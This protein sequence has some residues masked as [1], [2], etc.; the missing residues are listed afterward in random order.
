M[1]FVDPAYAPGTGTPEVGG[2]TSRQAIDL[3][4]ELRAL[5]LVAFDLV[6][7]SPP[8]DHAEITAMLA[9]NVVFEAA[10]MVAWQRRQEAAD[11]EPENVVR[12]PGPRR[13][14]RGSD[15]EQHGATLLPG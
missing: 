3:L 2:P 13:G 9:A 5:P 8:Y 12:Y 11:L 10:S 4:R 14:T 1:D 7:V 15:D 6:E